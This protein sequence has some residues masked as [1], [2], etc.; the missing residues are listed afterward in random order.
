MANALPSIRAQFFSRCRHRDSSSSFLDSTSRRRSSLTTSADVSPPASALKDELPADPSLRPNKF[1]CLSFLGP[2][3]VFAVGVVPSR[4]AAVAVKRSSGAEAELLLSRRILVPRRAASC[5]LLFMLPSDGG[6]LPRALGL[7]FPFAPPVAV[8]AT[9]FADR[10][11]P[12][13]VPFFRDDDDRDDADRGRLLPPPFLREADERRIFWFS[14]VFT[15][16]LCVFWFSPSAMSILTIVASQ[17][18]R[19]P[20]SASIA[21][22]RCFKSSR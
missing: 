12:V 4:S 14:M 1:I 11:R 7:L 8:V 22:E 21:K 2:F 6:R 17:H 5:R 10:G 13:A 3:A 20:L 18:R 16:L 9:A 19:D 15:P